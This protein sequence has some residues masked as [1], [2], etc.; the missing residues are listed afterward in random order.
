MRLVAAEAEG[1]DVGVLLVLPGGGT[2]EAAVFTWLAGVGFGWVAALGAPGRN[3]PT[4]WFT[5]V[6]LPAPL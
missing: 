6:V 3:S 1:R 5:R 2:G 4:I